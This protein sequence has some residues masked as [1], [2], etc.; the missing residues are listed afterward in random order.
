MINQRVE[1]EMVSLYRNVGWG[2][3]MGFG[4]CIAY[5]WAYENEFEMPSPSPACRPARSSEPG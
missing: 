5:E 4:G 1:S 3:T 2:C